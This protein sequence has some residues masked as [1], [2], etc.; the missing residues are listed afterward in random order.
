MIIKS[1]VLVIG[2]G[3]AGLCTALK[4]AEQ[5]QVT[6]V[7]KENLDQSNTKYAQGGITAVVSPDDS[8]ASHIEDTL[9][10]GNGIAHE[11]AVKLLAQGGKDAI[12]ELLKHGTS[13]TRSL[14]SKAW[15]QLDLGREGGHSH[16][17]IVHAKDR[18]G[19]AIETAL[20]KR[21]RADQNITILEWHTLI[22]LLTPHQKRKNSD[23]TNTCY[24]AIFY[25]RGDASITTLLASQTV[26]ATGGCGEIYEHTTN[27]A[28]ATG[29]GVA[30]AWRAGAKISNME[31]IQFHPTT[32]YHSKADSF[33]ISEALRGHGAILKDVQGEPFME[34]YHE[35]GSLAPRDIVARAIDKEM[36]TSGEPCVYLDIR[37]ADA[38]ELQDRFPKIFAQCLKF[39]IDISKDLIPVVPASHYCCGGIKVTLDGE[40]TLK[41]LYAVGEVSC[42][43]VH[44][45][46]RLASN[47]LL[48]AVVFAKRC[49]THILALKEI[50]PVC[51]NQFQTWDDSNTKIADEW[52]LISHN[53]SEI[54]RIMWDYVGIVRSDERLKRAMK[55]IKLIQEEVEH[56]YKRTKICTS[57]LEL[58][59]MATVAELII[60]SALLRK[61]S[62]GLH[63]NKNYPDKI[64]DFA[65][66][67]ILKKE[68]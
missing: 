58:R 67:T 15:K 31:F 49:A 63:F 40:T 51:E 14:D 13:F 17:R 20:V 23:T 54:Q 34:R 35:M 12:E 18:T 62:R 68:C 25:N 55:R 24:G 53:K 50:E 6:L 41:N 39:G 5:R 37:H 9:K 11:E 8:I 27:P 30:A 2:S 33:L 16:H 38:D 10:T 57:I 56:Y 65:F 28:I 64:A 21:A 60:E 29:D 42:T 45:A 32:L 66:D 44:G 4:L 61:E 46:N 52:V 1:D 26:L 22:E 7:T 48:E 47:S 59:N 36:K 19:F 43:G 3:I